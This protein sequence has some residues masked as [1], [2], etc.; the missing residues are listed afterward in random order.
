[1]VAFYQPSLA[2]APS[3]TPIAASTIL[4]RLHRLRRVWAALGT[5]TLLLA[6]RA[7][8]TRPILRLLTF[9]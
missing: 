6:I 2:A 4:F 9:T 1:M 3:P 7:S 8:D 5:V